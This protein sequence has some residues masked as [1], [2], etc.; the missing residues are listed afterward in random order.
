MQGIYEHKKDH[1]LNLSKNKYPD[2][3]QMK[4][5]LPK[6]KIQK[7]INYFFKPYN[8]D[9]EFAHFMRFRDND[10]NL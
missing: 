7:K 10:V 5:T 6:R 8:G 4:S 1:H 9:Q 2:E 3:E